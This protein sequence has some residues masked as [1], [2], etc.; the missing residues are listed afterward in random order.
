MK[1]YPFRK[2]PSK[3]YNTVHLINY[4]LNDDDISLLSSL[5]VIQEVLNEDMPDLPEYQAP[6]EESDIS[7]ELQ[8]PSLGEVTSYVALALALALALVLVLGEVRH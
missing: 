2:F 7:I 5:L 3:R 6:R 8:F 4:S 1:L